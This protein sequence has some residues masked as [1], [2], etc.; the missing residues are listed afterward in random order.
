MLDTKLDNYKSIITFFVRNFC[1]FI[2]VVS[3]TTGFS[4]RRD[5]GYSIFIRACVMGEF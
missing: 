1:N 3:L 5:G 4:L 2:E